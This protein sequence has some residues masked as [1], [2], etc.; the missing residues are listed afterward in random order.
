V[1][2]VACGPGAQTVDLAELLPCA[3]VRAIDLHQPFVEEANRRARARG[4]AGRMS[5]SCA[6]MRSLEFAPGTFD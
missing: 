4:M 3:T 2:D 6:D 5:A 1:L